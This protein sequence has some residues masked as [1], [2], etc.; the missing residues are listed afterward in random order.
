V[1]FESDVTVTATFAVTAPVYLV[2]GYLSGT[3]SGTVTLSREGRVSTMDNCPSPLSPGT[4]C[5]LGY[6]AG[7]VVTATETAHAGSVFT[8]WS[9]AC[10]G[11]GACSFTVN[12]PVSLS[13]NFDL[14]P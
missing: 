7:T 5:S 9:G 1:T 11:T 3:G 6:A 4:P 13:A 2:S 14:A 8:G 10:A 12:G